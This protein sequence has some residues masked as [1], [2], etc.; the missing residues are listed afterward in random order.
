MPVQYKGLIEETLRCRDGVGL[1]DVSHMG[2]FSL[3]GKDSLAAVQK[4]V[5]NDLSKLSV[6]QAQ[7]NMLCNPDG[8]VID[9][10]IVYRRAEDHT[11]ICVN[12]SNRQADWEWMKKHLPTTQDMRDESDETALIAVQGPHAERLLVE[13]TGQETLVKNLKYYWAAEA[14]VFGKP[15]YLSRT[16]YTG[17]DGFEIYIDQSHGVSTWDKLMEIGAKANITPCGLGARDTLRLEMGYPL[18]GHELSPT[19]S[20]LSAGLGWVV[21]LNLATAFIG[22]EALRKEAAAG[23]ARVLRAFTIGDRR[24]ARQGY[25]ILDERGEACGEITSGTQS[26]H[27]N[28]PIAMGFVDKRTAGLDKFSVEVRNDR[29]PATVTKLPFVKSS[30]K[31]N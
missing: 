1:F 2:Q 26:P 11:Y 14:K 5:T 20:P 7:Y 27:L 9:D 24:I 3:R 18:H 6:G 22:Q 10:L 4:L 23:P 21:K 16:G 31:K 8:G 29:I 17:E 25:K 30:A 28:A 19:I 15:C 13:A 12:A